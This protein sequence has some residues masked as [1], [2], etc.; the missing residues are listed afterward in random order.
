MNANFH[1]KKTIIIII[2]IKCVIV[3]FF[4]AIISSKKGKAKTFDKN[5]WIGMEVL[6]VDSKVARKFNLNYRRGLL[7]RR[8]FNNSPA[9]RGGLKQGD[10]I[11]RIEKTRMRNLVQLKDLINKMKP[12]K[13]VR[14]VVGR[15]DE[16]RNIYIR[17]EPRPQFLSNSNIQ[18]VS[19]P[20]YRPPVNRP[21]PYFYFGTERDEIEGDRFERE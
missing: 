17:V 4:F 9:S 2:A 20:N 18:Y 3:L 5:V 10:V 19:Y 6:P 12:D 21:Y 8:V 15:I 7:V 13:R 16:T 14:I 11:R 1:M